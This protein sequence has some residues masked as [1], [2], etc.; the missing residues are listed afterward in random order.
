MGGC[1]A[2]TGV[3]M[4]THVTVVWDIVMARQ[5]NWRKMKEEVAGYR[6]KVNTVAALETTV[7]RGFLDHRR[8]QL[9]VLQVDG[10]LPPISADP[11][12]S[13]KVP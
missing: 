6:I 10:T 3:V 9:E 4:C 2:G 8:D 5:S 7:S 11:L 12:A 1:C 13:H